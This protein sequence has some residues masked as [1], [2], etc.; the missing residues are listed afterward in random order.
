MQSNPDKNDSLDS[1]TQLPSAITSSKDGMPMV[2]VEA[3]SFLMGTSDHQV[4]VMVG[5]VDS[6]VQAGYLHPDVIHTVQ[7]QLLANTPQRRVYLDAFYI[8][9]Y[10]VTNQM[11]NMFCNETGHRK[12]PHWKNGSVSSAI[13]D[14][15][16]THVDW[17]D[18]QGY[19]QWAGKRLLTE[20]EWEKA[21]RGTDGRL[22]PWGNRFDYDKL[23]YARAYVPHDWTSELE[24]AISHRERLARAGSYPEGASPYGVL[25]MLGNVGEWVNDWYSATWYTEGTAVNPLGPGDGKLRVVR[26][27]SSLDDPEH[28][29]C[30][31]RG[32]LV[33]TVLGDDLGFRCAVTANKPLIT[34]SLQSSHL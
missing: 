14:C 20:A 9:R 29:S 22:F 32:C 6:W 28:L 24:H 1:S 15:P 31:N 26:G 5:L 23:H 11:Y 8:D 21:A 7:D 13:E 16:V 17:Y 27:C 34:R 3:G 33:P 30:S 19:A 18:A 25:D 4:E 10:E 12:P 2:L